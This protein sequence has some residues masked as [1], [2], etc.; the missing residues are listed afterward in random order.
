MKKPQLPQKPE[1]PNKVTVLTEL[2]V[3]R[4]ANEGANLISDVL[5]EGLSEYREI[6]AQ[7]EGEWVIKSVECDWHDDYTDLKFIFTGG[8][9]THENKR[10]DKEV[11]QYK[12]KLSKYE[13]D[14]LSYEERLKNW[15]DWN[16]RDSEKKKEREA[17]LLVEEQEKLK[18]QLAAVEKKLKK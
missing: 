5:N 11:L 8:V 18:K 9:I 16:K 15:A 2:E 13:S 14:L 7:I 17:Q 12:K 3:W 1:E 4:Y 10:Y 6:N